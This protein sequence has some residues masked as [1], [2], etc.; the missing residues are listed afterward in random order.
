MVGGAEAPLV[1]SVPGFLDELAERLVPACDPA[2]VRAVFARA[3]AGYTGPRGRDGLRVTA[4]TP[5]GVPFEASVTGGAGRSSAALRYVTETATGMPFF[6]PRLAAQRAALDDLVGWLPPVAQPAAAELQAAV[7][8]L[9]PDPGAVPAR[10]RFATTFGIVHRDD[11]PAGI[12]GLKLYGNLRTGEPGDAAATATDAL[13][14]LSGRWHTLGRLHDLLGDLP[15]LE[16]HFTTVEVD[17]TGRVGHKL[18]F[19]TRR[20]NAAGLAVAARRF[21]A[22][23]S[24]VADALRRAGVAD[25]VW[26]RRFF[27]CAASRPV[28]AAGDGDGSGG[29]ELSVHLSAKALRLDRDGMAR[30]AR[31]LVEQHGDPAGLH[32]V[33]GAVT[34]AGGGDCWTTTVVGL[35]LAPE[36]G[37]GKVNVYTTRDG[38]P[39]DGAAM[40]RG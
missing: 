37:V 34:A 5:S 30:L 40:V 3:S 25:D 38:E 18:Y 17:A 19:R 39:A 26:R 32:A 16:P 10:R 12:A 22:A 11:V 24:P 7:D 29:C 4:I 6:G 20:A 23:L 13:A 28:G 35:G 15:F 27:V 14:R 36:G 21:G 2:V 31:R 1:E 33:D 8:V 9:F